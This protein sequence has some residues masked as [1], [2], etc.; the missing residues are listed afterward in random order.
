MLPERSLDCLDAH[1]WNTEIDTRSH[2][3]GDFMR[4]TITFAAGVL[5]ALPVAAHHSDA[6]LDMDS[7]VAFEGTVTEFLLAESARLLHRRD[8]GR[9]R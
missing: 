1:N 9:T 6:G 5:L 4:D 8:D 3:G 7:V 2:S